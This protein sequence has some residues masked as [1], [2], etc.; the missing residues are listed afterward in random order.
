MLNKIILIFIIIFIN[1][2]YGYASENEMVNLLDNVA[3][4]GLNVAFRIAGYLLAGL[5]I[6]LLITFIFIK[7][8]G[9][10]QEK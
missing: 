9:N 3:T 10:K 1:F 4:G 5:V 7:I 6:I 8:L 2:S